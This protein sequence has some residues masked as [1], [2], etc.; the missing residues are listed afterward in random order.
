MK[1]IKIVYSLITDRQSPPIVIWYLYYCWNK[2]NVYNTY[3]SGSQSVCRDVYTG[4]PCSHEILSGLTFFLWLITLWIEEGHPE[5]TLDEK[6]C[7]SQKSLGSTD[8][9]NIKC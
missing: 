1:Y 3:T 7:L 5:K 6:G 4:V 8:V 2:H 9:Y